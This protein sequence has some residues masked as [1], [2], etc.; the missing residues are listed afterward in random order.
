MP[1][2]PNG[3]ELFY[4]SG[5]G[6]IV[7][8]KTRPGTHQFEWTSTRPL[9]ASPMPG[10]SYDVTSNGDR[11]LM[12]TPVDGRRQNELTVIVNWQAVLPR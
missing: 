4:E 2:W 1:R 7:A 5:A 8:V 11:F 12:M 9:F 3:R 6:Q 10:R